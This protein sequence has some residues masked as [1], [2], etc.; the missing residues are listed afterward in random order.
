MTGSILSPVEGFERYSALLIAAASRPAAIAESAIQT[1]KMVA[2]NRRI[3]RQPSAKG[4]MTMKFGP[5]SSPARRMR[6]RRHDFSARRP[7]ERRPPHHAVSSRFG[8][9]ADAFHNN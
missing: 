6:E 4:L 9:V 5:A 3:I 1:E 7:G 2:T 8:S